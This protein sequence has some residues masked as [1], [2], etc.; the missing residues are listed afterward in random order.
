MGNCGSKRPDGTPLMVSEQEDMGDMRQI[1]RSLDRNHSGLVNAL[2]LI[3]LYGNIGVQLDLG[4]LRDYLMNMHA[5]HDGLVNE[6]EFLQVMGL[7]KSGT[8][9]ANQASAAPASTAVTGGDGRAGYG[10][11]GGGAVPGDV[12]QLQR[13][14]AELEGHT[15]DLHEE[16]MSLVQKNSTL[17]AMH[18]NL[19][20]ER[21]PQFASKRAM[22]PTEADVLNLPSEEE[23][24]PRKAQLAVSMSG[25]YSAINSTLSRGTTDGVMVS[26]GAE[27]LMKRRVLEQAALVASQEPC[28]WTFEEDT[29]LEAAATKYVISSDGYDPYVREP[30]AT[31]TERWKLVAQVVSEASE[32]VAMK[33]GKTDCKKRHA[34]LRAARAKA[35]VGGE[36]KRGEAEGIYGEVFAQGRE[37][38]EGGPWLEKEDEALRRAVAETDKDQVTSGDKLSQ[39]NYWRKVSRAVVA[40]PGAQDGANKKGKTACRTRWGVIQS[41]RREPLETKGGEGGAAA[42]R[43]AGDDT[44]K[45]KKAD[46]AELTRVNTPGDPANMGG[47][48]AAEDAALREALDKYP[49]HKYD[50]TTASQSSRWKAIANM[51]MM[52]APVSYRRGKKECQDRAV[53]LGVVGA[54]APDAKDRKRG[55]GPWSTEED[56]ALI[57]ATKFYSKAVD[58]DKAA[59]TARWKNISARVNLVNRDD[60]SAGGR[61]KNECRVRLRELMEKK[62]KKKTK[63]KKKR[64]EPPHIN[65]VGLYSGLEGVSWD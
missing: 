39:I 32:N 24:K 29:A 58:G 31:T 33:R 4:R 46:D 10:G 27:E 26:P 18:D 43:G 16:N 42:G 53:A 23:W 13:R 60:L 47:W 54:A 12:H 37:A 63:T 52:H 45:G 9:D 35:G 20:A 56:A 62:K 28:D 6:Q 55:E 36:G 34:E 57:S 21:D 51:M 17:S 61:G 50:T 59:S 40:A 11:G 8:L 1:F 2:E 22:N 3:Q 49:G 25:D 5:N 41:Q 48:V 15:M 14:I 44:G 64:A 7:V 38:G 65:N 30:A 19:R